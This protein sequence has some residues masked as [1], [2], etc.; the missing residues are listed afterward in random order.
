MRKNEIVEK[1]IS[2]TFDFLRYLI[3]HPE[4]IEKLPDEGQ[5]EF[6]ETDFSS[7]ELELSSGEVSKTFLRVKRSFDVWNGGMRDNP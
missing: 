1:N 7:T 4:L 5:L 3:D 6:L 2:L